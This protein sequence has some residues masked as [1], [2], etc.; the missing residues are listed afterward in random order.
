MFV[1]AICFYFSKNYQLWMFI[2]LQLFRSEKS[3]LPQ[4]PIHTADAR[5]AELSLEGRVG[6][7]SSCSS[8]GFWWY[9]KS[10]MM[11]DPRLCPPNDTP[12]SNI[13]LRSMN[14]LYRRFSSLPTVCIIVCKIQHII[15]IRHIKPELWAWFYENESVPWQH[16]CGMC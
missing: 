7:H 2:I 12:P 3:K 5:S 9:N 15:L 16:K 6:S 11:R 4:W 8:V 1:F 13:G 14:K 10:N